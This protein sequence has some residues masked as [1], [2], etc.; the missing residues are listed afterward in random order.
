MIN[1]SLIAAGILACSALAFADAPAGQTITVQPGQGTPIAMTVVNTTSR[2]A[3]YRLTGREEA[4]FAWVR[5]G[6]GELVR[7]QT[8]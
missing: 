1:R 5:V 3:P 7:V 2:E 8:K 6:Q 4:G